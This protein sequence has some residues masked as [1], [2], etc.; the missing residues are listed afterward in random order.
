[1]AF[2]PAL[3]TARGVPL[4][5]DIVCTYSVVPTPGQTCEG[6]SQTW[7]LDVDRFRE[8]N[9]DAQCPD[10]DSSKEYCVIGTVTSSP[11]T[12]TTTSTTTNP[13]TTSEPTPPTTTT[14]T[15]TTA[16]TTKSASDHDPTIPGLAGDCDKFY[17]IVS[18]DQCD[19]VEKK[20]GISDS[21]FKQW[22]SQI[23]DQ[24]SNLWLGYYV[25]VHVP[26]ATTTSTSPG[27]SS[28][29]NG[30]SLQMPGIVDNCKTFHM[31]V[32]GDNCYNIQAKYNIS[33]DQ[34]LAWNSQVNHECTNLWADY[35]ICVGV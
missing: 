12:T 35:Y 34:I 8:L 22:N 3:I 4:R 13:T 25:C 23:N 31:V 28:P 2:L 27:G 21:Q 18:G 17:Q 15:K 10:L 7:G 29:T 24:C 20:N 6:L 9:P 1:M 5:R 16:T 30:P 32:S 33:L 11:T 26:G 14:T 19:L